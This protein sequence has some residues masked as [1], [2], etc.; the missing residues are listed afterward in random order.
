MNRSLVTST[1]FTLFELMA[2]LAIM[3]LLLAIAFPV[4]QNYS[5]QAQSSEIVLRFDALR[6][7]VAA[8]ARGTMVEQCGDLAATVNAANLG[9]DY[10]SLSM[11]FEAVGTDGYR[12]VMLVCARDDSHGASAVR[13]AHGAFETLSADYDVEAGAVVSDV[14]VSFALPLT[15]TSEAVCR[16]PVTGGTSACG[17]S[18]SSSSP[19]AATTQTPAQPP[20]IVIPA[21]ATPAAAISQMVAAAQ[22][23][24][25]TSVTASIPASPEA[26]AKL[27]SCNISLSGI[28]QDL[29]TGDSCAADLNVPNTPG[30][31]D[32]FQAKVCPQTCN[33][34][35][36]VTPEIQ[37]LYDEQ[38]RAATERT[39]QSIT[40]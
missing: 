4:Y 7:N 15:D 34:C 9:D 32:C 26:A 16:I 28:C 11:G 2:V 37:R 33:V 10:A 18:A 5:D 13:I 27:Q 25:P 12:P 24:D 6:T 14:M 8:D 40:Q 31:C 1:G 17:G 21:D 3:T 22:N 36:G 29:Y 38:W 35:A 30:Q 39:L 20:P 23:A 19:P